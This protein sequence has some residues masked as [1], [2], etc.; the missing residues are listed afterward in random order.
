MEEDR[1]ET[2]PLELPKHLISEYRRIAQAEDMTGSEVVAW[3]LS[4]GFRAYAAGERPTQGSSRFDPLQ[5]G[6]DEI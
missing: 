1:K 6:R 2:A 5:T 3:C 4:Y